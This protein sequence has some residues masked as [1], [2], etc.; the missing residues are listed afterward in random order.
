MADALK[1][2]HGP[3]FLTFFPLLFKSKNNF[4]RNLQ[5][6]SPCGIIGQNT[7]KYC[8]TYLIDLAWK[9]QLPIDQSGAH[10]IWKKVSPPNWLEGQENTQNDVGKSTSGTIPERN[11]LGEILSSWW[12][13]RRLRMSEPEGSAEEMSDNVKRQEGQGG[14]MNLWYFG[15]EAKWWVRTEGVRPPNYI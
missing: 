7:V 9:I 8:L 4:L 3:A 1:M 11:V 15:M 10:T 13:R 5:H 6:T 14:D 2:K 12:L